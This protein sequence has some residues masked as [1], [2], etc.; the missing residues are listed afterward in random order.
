MTV[1]QH[2]C[3]TVFAPSSESFV[4]DGRGLRSLVFGIRLL[5]NWRVRKM[6]QEAIKS[7]VFVVVLKIDCSIVREM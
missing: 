6:L 5:V 2:N 1:T 4:F 7:V 3:N